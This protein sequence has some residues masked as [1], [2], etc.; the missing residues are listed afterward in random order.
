MGQWVRCVNV[1]EGYSGYLWG[2]DIA[3]PPQ[4]ADHDD[5]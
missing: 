5:S 3:L 4:Q 1:L 2:G